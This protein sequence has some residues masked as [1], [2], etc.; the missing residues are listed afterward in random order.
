MCI[1]SLADSQEAETLANVNSRGWYR[2]FGA[3]WAS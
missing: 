1:N 3:P 2:Y